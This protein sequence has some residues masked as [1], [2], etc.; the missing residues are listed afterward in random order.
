VEPERLPFTFPESTILEG[1]RP[2][3]VSRSAALA[4]ATL[5]MFTPIAGTLTMT[6]YSLLGQPV[7]QETR[8]VQT[9]LTN[10]PFSTHRL[11]RGLYAVSVAYNGTVRRFSFMVQE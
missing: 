10:L 6:V 11:A 5:M 4:E 8:E 9:G 3:L 2:S 1:I 7:V